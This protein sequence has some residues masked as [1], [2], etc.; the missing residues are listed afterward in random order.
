MADKPTKLEWV[1]GRRLD[2]ALRAPAAAVHPGEQQHVRRW[3]GRLSPVELK[4]LA[5]EL[6]ARAAPSPG[7]RAERFGLDNEGQLTLI[8]YSARCDRSLFLKMCEAFRLLH[9]PW[10]DA[11]FNRISARSRTPCTRGHD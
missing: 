6:S 10:R 2:E 9:R 5:Q 3:L 8:A 7:R 1:I 4:T 11:L